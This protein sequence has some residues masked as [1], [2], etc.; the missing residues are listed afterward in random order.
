[1]PKHAM[2]VTNASGVS[3]PGAGLRLR[4]HF[5]GILTLC[6]AL[7]GCAG[8]RIAGT[9]ILGED[10]NFV[11]VTAGAGE[12]YPKLAKR[13]LGGA[14]QAWRIEDANDGVTLRA[15]MNVVVPK[16]DFNR[17][18]VYPDGYQVVPI[19]S[20]HR[21]GEG[22]GKLS[23]SRKQFTEQLQV[24]RRGGYR[25]VSLRDAAAFL[26]AEKALPKKAVVLTIDDGYQSVYEIA[27]PV[28]REFGYPA[29]VFIYTDYIGNGG[30][31]WQQMK[32]ME[33]SGL[34]SFQA[35]SKTHE[36]LTV[37]SS[38]ETFSDYKARLAKEVLVPGQVLGR[39]MSEP[40]FGYAYPFGAVNRVVVDELQEKGYEIA[41]TVRRGANPFYTFPYGL[42]R[43][44]IYQAGDIQEF[45]RALTTFE[46][47]DLR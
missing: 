14:S 12:T 15:G 45:E 35:H 43:T 40:V 21:F 6:T 1:M 30:L 5:I 19:L 18:G 7:V 32:E 29:T 11:V 28:L 47:R 24:L 41:A 23:V 37:K 36:N 42:H 2:L 4:L 33:A 20:Y 25:P 3:G 13:F 34:I 27:F 26:R 16:N 44:M 8:S 39:R 17:I 31:T 38:A 46:A 9:R 10:S 22:R